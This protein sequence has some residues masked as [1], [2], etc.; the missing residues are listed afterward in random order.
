VLCSS[1]HNLR[2]G[3]C[4][5]DH[6]VLAGAENT[7]CWRIRN[8]VLQRVFALDIPMVPSSVITI[9]ANGECLT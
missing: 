8:G 7:D 6:P 2:T 4:D 9:A 3:M 1:P 5:L